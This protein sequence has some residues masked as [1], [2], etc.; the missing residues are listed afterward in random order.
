[1]SL[2]LVEKNQRLTEARL[3]RVVVMIVMRVIMGMIMRMIV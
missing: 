2:W 3:V 1:M